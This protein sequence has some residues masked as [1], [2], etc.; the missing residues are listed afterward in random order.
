M[1]GDGDARM[2]LSIPQPLQP[3]V[4]HEV[5]ASYD[6]ASGLGALSQKP[7]SAAAGSRRLADLSCEIHTVTR[8]RR[9][10]RLPP[11]PIM[12]GASAKLTSHWTAAEESFTGTLESPYAIANAT[13]SADLPG[14]HAR[15]LD[16]SALIAAWDFSRGLSEDGIHSDEVP[17]ITGCFNAH[18]VN[19]PLRAVPGH[20]G[21][22]VEDF[23]T[24]P[25][26]YGAIRLVDRW[27]DTERWL[28]RI[29]LAVPESLESGFY[30]VQ[31]RAANTEE[32]VPFVISPSRQP[33]LQIPDS[34]GRTRQ[35]SA[36]EAP[37]EH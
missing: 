18:C 29:T 37:S 2:E 26:R 10:A 16:A 25:E 32:Y 9:L 24:A 13:R 11:A 1:A 27:P 30:A 6:L 15:R 36:H 7:C 33:P 19:R 35:I 14:L 31:L 12:I 23:R 28:A 17:D 8:H 22:A 34:K 3:G 5:A 4:W 21:D 20:L